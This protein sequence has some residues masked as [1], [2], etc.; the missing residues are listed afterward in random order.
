MTS[1]TTATLPAQKGLLAALNKPAK[2]KEFSK[3]DLAACRI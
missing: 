1:P 2:I 3:K